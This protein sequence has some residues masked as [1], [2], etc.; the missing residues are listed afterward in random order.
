MEISSTVEM[1]E[2]IH[3][4]HVPRNEP[5]IQK[6]VNLNTVSLIYSR[7]SIH[8]ENITLALNVTCIQ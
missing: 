3:S 7:V 2:N 6:Q 1:M 4:L 8:K 5:Y